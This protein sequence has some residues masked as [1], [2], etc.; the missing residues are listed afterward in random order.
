MTFRQYINIL[1]K[2]SLN[3]VNQPNNV[4]QNHLSN[5]IRKQVEI[6]TP[7]SDE[8]PSERIDSLLKNYFL[9]HIKDDAEGKQQ[10]NK[11][12]NDQSHTQNLDNNKQPV[13]ET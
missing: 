4:E 6:H 7:P 1:K 3:F 9:A 2:S 10:T 12:D 13:A 8:L 5:S 11:V